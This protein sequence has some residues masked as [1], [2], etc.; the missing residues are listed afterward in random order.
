MHKLILVQVI[1]CDSIHDELA[2]QEAVVEHAP[3]HGRARA[4]SRGLLGVMTES[5]HKALEIHEITFAES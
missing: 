4:V 1:T 5:E 2:C 3:A